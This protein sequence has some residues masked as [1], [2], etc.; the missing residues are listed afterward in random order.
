MKWSCLR[1]SRNIFFE[2]RCI[3]VSLTNHHRSLSRSF[4]RNLTENITLFKQKN[5]GVGP[6]IFI[7]PLLKWFC[8]RLSTNIFSGSQCI[9]V[10]ETSLHRSLRGLFLLNLTENIYFFE[11][12]NA[13]VGPTNFIVSLLKWS[14]LRLSRNIFI[15]G[16]CICVSVTSHHRSLSR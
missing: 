6:K 5:W 1:L 11:Y 10:S 3:P 2:S 9:R 12:K 14:C 15:A 7:V 4:L 8:F 16:L 13:E